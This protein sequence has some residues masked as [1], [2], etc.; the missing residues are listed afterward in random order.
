MV[1]VED[2]I[3]EYVIVFGAVCV[4]LI[5]NYFIANAFQLMRNI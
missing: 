1:V 3:H 4:L 2:L 5:V